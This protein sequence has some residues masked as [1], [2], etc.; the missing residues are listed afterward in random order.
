MM[1]VWTPVAEE[2]AAELVSSMKG[3]RTGA[4]WR[5]LQAMLARVRGLAQYEGM[6]EG[7][8]ESYFAPCRIIYRVETD[9][10][11]ILTLQPVGRHRKSARY[12][13]LPPAR[14]PVARDRP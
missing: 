3:D 1:I 11:V 4:A 9:R 7:L 2:R 8:R 10:M 5:W 6:G 12:E 14:P 13:E